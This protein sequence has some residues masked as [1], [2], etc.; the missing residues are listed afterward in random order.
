[1][2]KL[3]HSVKKGNKGF[4]LVEL[5]IVIAIMVA[6]IAVMGPQYIKYVQDSRDA[7]VTQAAQDVL[8]VVKAEVNLGHLI[9]A[10]NVT[11]G[12]V[13]VGPENGNG[14]VRVTLS[15]GLMYNDNGSTDFEA[16]CGVDDTKIV[17]SDLKYI[18][19]ITGNDISAHP[20]LVSIEMESTESGD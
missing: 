3:R 19:R 13:T 12:N 6:L 4:S 2:F 5:I 10:D 9:F 1:M 8:A 14:K 17:K 16:I 7:V 15:N 20:E 18:I 11:E